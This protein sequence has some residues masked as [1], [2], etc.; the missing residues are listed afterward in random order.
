MLAV[1]IRLEVFLGGRTGRFVPQEHRLRVDDVNTGLGLLYF[2][3]REQHN[4]SFGA[5]S[6]SS[7]TAREER[8]P[9]IL[10]KDWPPPRALHVCLSRVREGRPG[11]YC[12]TDNT[13]PAIRIC[14]ALTRLAAGETQQSAA[15][16]CSIQS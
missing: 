2:T 7:K 3:S 1:G 10:W 9:Y 6:S 14:I 16:I 12:S 13:P 8:A 15:R 5:S 4:A 11:G